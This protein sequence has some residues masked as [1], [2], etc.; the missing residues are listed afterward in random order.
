[1]SAREARKARNRE[2]KT[3]K[4]EKKDSDATATFSLSYY[5]CCLCLLP[6]RF[7]KAKRRAQQQLQSAIPVDAEVLPEQ[8]IVSKD[9][10]TIAAIKIQSVMRG[11]QGR[12]AM[13]EYWR[14]AI[15][16]E[17]A[18]WL[19]IIR[20]RELAWLEKERRIVARKQ[21]P[22]TYMLMVSRI[23]A[24]YFSCLNCAVCATIC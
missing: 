7:R 14:M 9:D 17:S 18:Y 16:E 23:K 6:K 5:F 1:M 15:E 22:K 10:K 12:Q 8:T 11:F 2:E 3:V 19:A 4:E 13:K 20:A 24:K 21:V